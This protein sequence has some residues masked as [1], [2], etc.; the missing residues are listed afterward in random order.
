MRVNISASESK[1]RKALQTGVGPSAAR[2]E[3]GGADQSQANAGTV[4]ETDHAG[5]DTSGAD[6][7]SEASDE[8]PLHGRRV[9]RRG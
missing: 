2:P 5:G 7:H 9:K 6:A 1:R 4:V 3:E 8:Q